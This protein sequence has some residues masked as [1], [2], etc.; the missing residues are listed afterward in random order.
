[1]SLKGPRHSIERRPLR[2]VTATAPARRVR[3][4]EDGR[5]YVSWHLRLTLDCG[6]EVDGRNLNAPKYARCN[7]CPL[8]A[9]AVGP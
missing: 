4:T 8:K 1:M 3:R 9:L 2:T 6:H 5:E 7:Q